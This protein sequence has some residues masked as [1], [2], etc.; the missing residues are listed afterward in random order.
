MLY[1]KAYKAGI[2]A[3]PDPE[4]DVLDA[5]EECRRHGGDVY[6]YNEEGEELLN[7]YDCPM[8]GM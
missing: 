3:K 6:A 2:D 4:V 5:C 1:L 8:G 7:C